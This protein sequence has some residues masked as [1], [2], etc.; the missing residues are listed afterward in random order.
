MDSPLA[1]LL[2]I[3]AYFLVGLAMR[4]SGV[5]TREQA[6]F[7]LRFVFYVT[8]PALV[9]S[10]VSVAD[11]SRDTMLL[12][13]AGMTVNVICASAAIV[14]VGRI[15]LEHRRAGAVVLGAAFTNMMFSFPFIL[16]ILGPAALAN[17]ILFDLGN[18]IFFSVAAYSISMYYGGIESDSA[19]SYL[20]R[21]IRAPIFIAV[22]GALLVNALQLTVPKMVSDLL[23]P[24]GSATTPLVLIS[25]GVMFSTRG[26]TGGLTVATV[27]LRMFLGL[28]VGAGIVLVFG[29]EGMTAA[30]VAVSAA[31]P[32]GF[33]TVPLASIGNLDTAQA[34]SA[35][36]A[37]IAIGVISTTGLLMAAAL[38]LGV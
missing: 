12:P 31:A 11:F 18:A 14:Y 4:H 34:A 36:S 23:A 13:I 38:W 19:L 26:M 30:V 17:A 7:L 21:T 37:S 29:F 1:A 3:V 15:N 28:L 35:L 25:V 32:I 8:L 16:A 24:L 6:T 22:A 2:P 27:L 9:F 20:T 5:A 10:S 33:N